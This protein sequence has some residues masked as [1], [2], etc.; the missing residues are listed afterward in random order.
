MDQ[1]LLNF[2]F[3]YFE[4]N[5]N[6]KSYCEK[7]YE[8]LYASTSGNSKINVILEKSGRG[9][10]GYGIVFS[11]NRSHVASSFTNDPICTLIN[12][13]ASLQKQIIN[14]QQLIINKW[15]RVS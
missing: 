14:Q 1:I 4:P 5:T 3:I 12:I 15:Q 2:K 13:E 10:K 11:K 6:L 7:L 8:R 9:F